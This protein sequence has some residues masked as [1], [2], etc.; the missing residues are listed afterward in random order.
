MRCFRPWIRVG[1]LAALVLARLAS[2]QEPAAAP[3]AATPDPAAV[4]ASVEIVAEPVAITPTVTA[5]P[6]EAPAAPAPAA[7]SPA[8][9][10]KEPPPVINAQVAALTGGQRT[11]A[12]A[13]D[14]YGTKTSADPE[15]IARVRAA[16]AF[17]SGHHLGRLAAL[18]QLGGE[19]NVFHPTGPV[20]WQGDRLPDAA[21]A[22]LIPTEAWAGW[23]WT[24]KAQIRA[25]LMQSHWG[26]GLL[27][28]DG[29][30]EQYGDN[31]FVQPKIGDRVVR[32]AVVLTPF[33]GSES[34]L[35]G[36]VVSAAVDHVADDD[37]LVTGDTA[38]QV[39]GA[40]KLHSAVDRWVGVYYAGRQQ[41]NG[42]GRELAVHAI[43]LAGDFAWTSG[44]L[45]LRL[46]GEA[47]MIVGSTTLGPSP[48][49]NE[50]KVLQGGAVARLT[51]QL[52]DL[53]GQLDAAWLSGDTSLD[54]DTVSNFRAD[55]NL[56]FGL[57]LF[58]RLLAAQSGRAKV[59]ASDPNLV[60]VP[61]FDLD[62]LATG[63]AATSAILA[64]PKIG[65]RFCECL[66]VYGG[67]VL[68][69]APAPLQDPRASKTVGGGAA[70][71]YVGKAPE[72]TT[73][74]TELA[75]GARYRWRP[76]TMG[77]ELVAGI[78]GALLLPGGALAG[79][80]ESIAAGRLTL[81]LAPKTTNF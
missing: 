13:A 73:L 45:G 75:L 63:G 47:V 37:I 57:I 15:V 69:F 33:R 81:A 48:E 28:N 39:I 16:V 49:F 46:Q 19:F 80:A 26:L 8:P 30:P 21:A 36:L 34:A 32:G 17:D 43:D 74:G 18:I 41:R 25:G 54:D 68:A 51:A 40:V 62:R 78:E 59:S 4:P 10:A 23:R 31:W 3:P 55:P 14:A 27:A 64:F 22:G 2:A 7:A 67:A 29:R 70:A 52:A 44:D 72:G 53:R 71:N 76:P 12:F 79:M 66:Q 35:A 1:C 77:Y 50:H 56:Q 61:N 60:G 11:G 65:W 42:A 5:P 6:V 58:P 24:D 9:V 38:E 20:A